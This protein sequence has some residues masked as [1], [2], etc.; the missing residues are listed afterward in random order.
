MSSAIQGCVL[1]GDGLLDRLRN[2]LADLADKYSAD[3]TQQARSRAIEW[4][5]QRVSP[6]FAE[7]QRTL[8]QNPPEIA[9]VDGIVRGQLS[10][11]LTGLHAA[12]QELERQGSAYMRFEISLHVEDAGHKQ[13]RGFF[14]FMVWP[15]DSMWKPEPTGTP[16]GK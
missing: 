13:G 10:A 14:G 4:T 9:H 1:L 12:G 3:E 8:E 2:Q 6:R 5:L 15:Y 16:A 11:C 7:R